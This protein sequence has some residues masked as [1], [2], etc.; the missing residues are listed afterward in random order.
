MGLFGVGTRGRAILKNLALSLGVV[1]LAAALRFWP[2]HELGDRMAWLTF[3]P[4]TVVVA[5]SGGFFAGLLAA[6]LSCLVVLFAWPWL[7]EKPFVDDPG[8]WMGLWVFLLNCAMISAVAEAM[9]RARARAVRSQA[10]AED[11]NRAKTVFLAN[12]SHELRTPLNAILGFSRRLRA[13][14]QNAEQG[15]TLDI[16]VRSGEHLLSLI[17]AVLDLS[18]IEAGRVVLQETPTDLRQL[19]EEVLALLRVR[20]AEK[21]VR[22]QGSFDAALPGHLLVDDG[23]LRQ[24]LLNLVGNALKFTTEGQVTLRIGALP[25]KAPLVH[26]VRFAVE[27]TGAGIAPHEQALIFEPFAQGATRA[28]HETGTGLGLAISRQLIAL[29]G[30]RLQLEGSSERGSCF[31]FELRLRAAPNAA[32]AARPAL[33]AVVGIEPGRALPRVLIADDEPANRRLLRSLLEPLGFPVQEAQNGLEVLEIL[34]RWPA[35]VMLLDLRMPGLDGLEVTRRVRADPAHARLRLIAITAHALEDERQQILAAGCDQVIAKPF[36]DEEIFEAL[37]RFF[38]LRY[39]HAPPPEPRL[40]SV[41]LQASELDGLDA[42]LRTELLTGAELLDAQR[43]LE[44]AGRIE[45]SH[46]ALAARIRASVSELRF[47]ELLAAAEQDEGCV[48]R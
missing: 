48:P 20:A 8:D 41:P 44:V 18:K 37:Q 17:N 43:C 14:A 46:P 34:G 4:A 39:R 7:I 45:A 32:T 5:V 15:E 16:V 29:M 23:R 26:G 3:Y 47:D 1:A 25:E 28:R 36:R 27:D 19:G 24:V 33:G 13:T 31:A 21:G 35:D 11:A 2:L 30:G 6:V 42:T 22:L 40:A 10:Q 38:D 9:R 12:M